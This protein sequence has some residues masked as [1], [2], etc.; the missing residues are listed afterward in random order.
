MVKNELISV[1]H[2]LPCYMGVEERKKKVWGVG[3]DWSANHESKIENE[4]KVIK[5]KKRVSIQFALWYTYILKE[6]VYSI[7][8][9]IYIYA[10]MYIL[11]IYL[12]R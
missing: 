6:R 9:L 2:L 3:D 10:F 8:T 7:C 5:W 11:L 4:W 12:Y 1:G